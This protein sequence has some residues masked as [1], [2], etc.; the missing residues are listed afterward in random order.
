MG[1][2]NANQSMQTELVLSPQSFVKA[3]SAT[4]R[5]A[6]QEVISATT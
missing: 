5:Q 1:I 6:S 4:Q 3:F 2:A